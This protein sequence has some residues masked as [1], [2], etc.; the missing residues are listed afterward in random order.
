MTSSNFSLSAARNVGRTSLQVSRLGFGASGIA[1]LYRNVS[2]AEAERTIRYAIEQG[3]RLFDTAPLYGVGLSERRVGATL[4]GFPRNSYVLATKVGRI[5]TSD[6]QWVFDFSH[7]GVRRSLEAS[8]KRLKVDHVDILHIHDPD[9]HYRQALDEAFPALADL[10][11]QGVIKAIG[12]G[13]NQWQMLANFA[14]HADFD[15]FLLAGRYTLLEQGAVKFLEVCQQKQIS[16]F[17]AGIYNS[18]VLATGVVAGAKFQYADAP[19]EVLAKVRR[20][21]TVC[22]R[23]NV[24]LNAAAVQFV[25]AHPAFTSLIVGAESTAQ[26]AETVAAFQIPIPAAFWA[27]LRAEM[28][29]EEAAPIPEA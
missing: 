20:L 7:D 26:Y 22:E 19:P 28:L 14:E 17:A 24:P 9:D 18:G 15:C 27:E 16:V 12:A 10:R 2:D 23:H 29:I 5:I 8:L 3:V 6:S 13:M 11:S 21:Q 25:A 4:A 1:N